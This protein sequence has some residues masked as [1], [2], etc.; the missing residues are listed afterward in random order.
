MLVRP[1]VFVFPRCTTTVAT[2]T[3]DGDLSSFSCFFAVAAL[4]Q[5]GMTGSATPVAL[6]T[7]ARFA[8][9]HFFQFVVDVRFN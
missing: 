6:N 9:H 2:V 8:Q 7:G 1:V 4:N 3:G 5:F